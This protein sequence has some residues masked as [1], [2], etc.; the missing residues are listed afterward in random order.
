LPKGTAG[1]RTQTRKLRAEG[2]TVSNGR[3]RLSE[4]QWTPDLD[5]LIW[6]PP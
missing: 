6:G 3:V 1:Y 4:F 5:E 2:V